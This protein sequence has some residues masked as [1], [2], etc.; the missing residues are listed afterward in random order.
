MSNVLL[1]AGD[2]WSEAI[3]VGSEAREKI[4]DERRLVAVTNVGAP[5]LHLVDLAPPLGFG[6]ALLLNQLGRVAGKAM[7]LGQG[8][9]VAG[10]EERNLR[11]GAGKARLAYRGHLTAS[12]EQRQRND[13]A[14]NRARDCGGH[15]VASIRIECQPLCR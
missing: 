13:H 2:D 12:D 1:R 9:C 11:T 5:P 10:R 15:E 7:R 3:V 14:H 4:S 6:E 8:P